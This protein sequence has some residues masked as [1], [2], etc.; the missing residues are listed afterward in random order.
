MKR[1]VQPRSASLFGSRLRDRVLCLLS[2]VP[3]IHIRGAAGILDAGP[4][5]TS[6]AIASL[7]RIGVV[8]SRRAL[9]SR[10]V[11]LNSRWYAAAELGPL[12]ARMAAADTELTDL[13]T[14]KRTRPRRTG[15]PL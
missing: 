3:D 1:V 9:G 2:L 6:K 4:S 15:K 7:E 12:L 13:I 14:A 10:R 11:S 8:V 5:E